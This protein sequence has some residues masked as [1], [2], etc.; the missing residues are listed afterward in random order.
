[1]AVTCGAEIVSD[2]SPSVTNAPLGPRV[3]TTYLQ[4]SALESA[5]ACFATSPSIP[6]S[7]AASPSFGTTTS[8]KPSQP[9][10]GA[11]GA[12][13]ST[14]V[15]LFSFANFAA[16]KLPSVGSSN[17]KSKISDSIMVFA[18]REM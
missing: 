13:V 6:V 15:T 8:T 17:C 3:I 12:G 2:L 7:A 10:N 14:T 5:A 1:M 4:P 9:V 18:C 11:T 16:A